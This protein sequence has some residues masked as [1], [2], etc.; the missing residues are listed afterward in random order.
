MMKTL[1]RLPHLLGYIMMGL[2][3]QTHHVVGQSGDQILDGIGETSTIARYLFRGDLRDWSRNNLHARYAGDKGP[4]F[5]DQKGGKVLS[6]PGTGKNY[7]QLPKEALNDLESLSISTWVFIPAQA[8]SYLFDFSFDAKNRITGRIKG[9]GDNSAFE[10]T[11]HSAAGSQN[12]AIKAL[13]TNEW[14][15]IAGIVD[16]PSKTLS[17]YLN[18]A[19]TGETKPVNLDFSTLSQSSQSANRTLTVGQANNATGTPMA[20]LLKDFRIY[21]VAL[22]PKQLQTIYTNAKNGGQS[23]SSTVNQ[24]AKTEDD[25]QS[26]PMTQA[27]LYN[28]Y[29]EKVADVAVK[30]TVGDAP[31]LPSFLEGT[32]RH[33][34]QGPKVRV[35]WPSPTDNSAVQTA[36]NYTIVGR[37]PGTDLQPKAFVTVK[38][39]KKSAAPRQSLSA[40]ALNE[41]TLNNDSPTEKNPFVAN[42]D[43]FVLTLAKTNPDD[44][45]YMFRNAFGVAQPAGAKPLGVWDSQ[46]TKLRGHA[47]GHYL[48]AIA[49]AYASTGYD[50]ALKA[51]FKQKIDQMVETLYTLSQ[52][53]GKPQKEGG[54]S[55]ADPRAVPTGPGKNEF[56]SDLST[57]G[58]RTDYWNWGEGYISAY[59]P[60]QFIMLEQG[61]KYGGQ[62]NQVW[63]PY[64]TLHKILAGLLDIY[65]QTGNKK[66]LEVATGM[67]DWVESRLSALPPE[68]L[69]AIWNTYIAGEFGGMNE[70]MAH[71]YQLTGESKYWKTAQL[72]DNVDMFFG[73]AARTHGLAKNVDT[74]RGLHAN[75]HIPQIVGSIEMYGV[76]DELDY[77]K[78]ADNFW[79][80]AV[81]DYMYSIGGVAGARNPVNA[82]CF[83]GE[84]STLYQ[85]GFSAGGQNETCAT[86]NMLKLTSSLFMFEQRPELMDYYERGLYNHILASVAEDSP[87]N[88]YHVPIRPA[89]VKQFGNPHMNG[90]TCCNGTAIESSTKLQHAIYFKSNDNKNLYVNLF[91]PSTLTWTERDVRIEQTTD[92]PKTD[93]TKL[94]V[95]GKGK[96]AI[97]LRV[98]AWAT[99]GVQV[100][101][102]GKL[103]NVKAEAGS[104]VKLARNWKDGD[105]IEW[106]L[107][108]QFRLEPVM[109]Q[110]NIASLFYGPILLAAQEP[111]ARKDW[112]PVTLN[113]QDISQSIQGDP[114]QLHF[115]IDGVDFKPFYESYGRHS[116]YLDV[117][118]K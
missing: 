96:F 72:F 6:L 89:S 74:F 95:H 47:T 59:P 107:P 30:T 87:A 99:K 10:L 15:H 2:L 41:V 84:P 80:K 16:L 49:Q 40:F 20:G 71:L 35:I 97:N 93:Q 90:F 76:S 88:T 26:F 53:S 23:A 61:A 83:I 68:T 28:A 29:L 91:I 21:R 9:S 27:Q 112:R 24:G 60:D 52:L 104:Y 18:G 98:P 101:I 54:A 108:F 38:G 55:V 57:E 58:I 78:I 39:G 14:I 85:N 116:V 79:Y 86:Y 45:L 73:N 117:T 111:E 11:V 50:P 5:K 118:L 43:K 8:E 1:K 17:V 46:D 19:K 63:A 92:F 70:T 36:G 94:T 67:A 103:E 13:P 102:N 3:L 34:M 22:T 32:Y 82:E 4:Q 62:L 37:V 48:T 44:F 106:Q 100:K 7:L 64:Y 113:A 75:Q 115:T 65:T 25:L 42:R 31:R 77:F 69:R 66:A 109:D 105:M 81:N 51:N 56:N 33:G 12:A 114:G 110:Q